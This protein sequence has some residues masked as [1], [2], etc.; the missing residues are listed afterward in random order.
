LIAVDVIEIN[1]KT[2]FLHLFFGLMACA[3]AEIENPKEEERLHFAHFE[4]D[5]AV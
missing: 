2:L 3:K 4:L 5:F 1:K